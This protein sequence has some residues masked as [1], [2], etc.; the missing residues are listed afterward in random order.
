[1]S[2]VAD[3]VGIGDFAQEDMMGGLEHKSTSVPECEASFYCS[4]KDGAWDVGQVYSHLGQQN[5]LQ[6]SI[7]Q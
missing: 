4:Q 1:M 2:S 3:V 5:L 7:K 6:L